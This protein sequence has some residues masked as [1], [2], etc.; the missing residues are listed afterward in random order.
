MRI[1]SFDVGVKHLA[2]VECS[3]KEKQ[4]TIDEWKVVVVSDTA[5]NMIENII[6]TL[7]AE[8]Y[9]K[10]TASS[11]V[12]DV[13]LIENQPALRNPIMKNIQ[14]CIHT[15][16]AVMKQYVGCVGTVTSVSPSSKLR[17]GAA[18]FDGSDASK[19]SYKLRKELSIKTCRTYLSDGLVSNNKGLACLNIVKNE[20]MTRHFELTKKKDD[21]S[22]A[23]LQAIWYVVYKV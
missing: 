19:L 9:D 13:V 20:D 2:Y 7:D 15:Y 14:S 16:F 4:L 10:M 11:F 3:L 1:L 22:D 18:P 17:I 12:Y 8:F 23:L 5:Q 21:L 6:E